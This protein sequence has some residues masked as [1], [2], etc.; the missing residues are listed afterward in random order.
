M[1]GSERTG[2]G[3]FRTVLGFINSLAQE[4]PLSNGDLDP[5][6]ARFAVLQIGGEQ[7]PEVLLDFSYSPSSISS[8][9]FQAVYRDSSARL[10]GA[11]LYAAKNLVVSPGGRFRGVRR[12]AEISFVFVTDGVVSDRNMVQAVDAM[13]KANVVSMAIAV[14]PEVDRARLLQLTLGDTSLIFNLKS[15]KEMTAPGVVRSIGRCLG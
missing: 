9:A 7:D 2:P 5:K 15:F 12:N 3:N 14:G 8:L 10:G 13:R 1:D 11:I 6:G 4:I